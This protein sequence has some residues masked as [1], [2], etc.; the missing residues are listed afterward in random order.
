MKIAIKDLIFLIIFALLFSICTNVFE[1]KGN[2]YGSDVISF[3][4]QPKN[5]LDIIFFGSSHSY[6]TFSP[7]IIEEETG[8]VGYNFAT[9][10][11]PIYITYHYMLEALKTQHPRYFILETKML[12]VDN[13]YTIE[14]VVRDALDK[15][16]L[17]KNK[18][19]AIK[20]SV[21]SKKD[22]IS[23]YLNIIKYHSRYNELNKNDIIIG[24]TQI[25]LKNRG[26]ISLPANENIMINNENIIDISNKEKI[27]EKNLEYL[28]KIVNLAEENEIEL[29]FVKAPCQLTE[30]DQKK[31]N[32]L[33]EY[34]K[35]KN[36]DYIDYNEH[37]EN[38]NLKIGDFYDHGHLS[39][40]GSE[41]VSKNFSDYLKNKISY[42]KIK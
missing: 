24:L 1:L 2:G 39:G 26:Y 10:Q 38:L 14:G 29:I 20:A 11:Q 37:L 42:N 33:K 22:R 25:G 3:Y 8:L 30:D 12:S 6:A 41:K 13:E 9:Q 15:M 27:S 5:S 36:I 7:D 28:E 4:N 35:E 32:W 19:D 17:S 34:A 40:T 16:K 18:I 23:Y 21:E 31:Y